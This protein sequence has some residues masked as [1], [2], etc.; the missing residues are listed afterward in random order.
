MIK[1]PKGL[2]RR[3][4]RM[5]SASTNV[6]NPEYGFGEQRRKRGGMWYCVTLVSG[7]GC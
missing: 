2:R 1:S 7:T 5:R 3:R 6:E 4:K